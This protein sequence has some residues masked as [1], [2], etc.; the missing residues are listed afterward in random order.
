RPRPNTFAGGI[1]AEASTLLW[2]ADAL[3]VLRCYDRGGWLTVDAMSGFKFL[4]LEE[5]LDINDFAA[6]LRNGV[7]NFNGQEFRQ[8]A[9]TFLHDRFATANRFYGGGLG[10]RAHAPYPALPPRP[11]SQIWLR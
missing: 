9:I 7:A 2:G 8:P 4:S 11:T 6:A 10:G 1:Q 3:P 5:S